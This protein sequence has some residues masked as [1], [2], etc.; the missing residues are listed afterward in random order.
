MAG[1]QKRNVF[2]ASL[3]HDKYLKFHFEMKQNMILT[4][5]GRA[6]Q[7]HGSECPHPPIQLRSI[8]PN[9]IRVKGRVA[10]H[11]FLYMTY[12][13]AHNKHLKYFHEK[14][15]VKILLC[16][17]MVHKNAKSIQF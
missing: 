1:P 4:N 15:H 3:S 2:A 9:M 14:P 11:F 7:R 13:Y 8:F 16:A 5:M 10:N 17:Q 12:P 6:K